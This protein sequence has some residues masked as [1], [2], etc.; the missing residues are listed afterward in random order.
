MLNASPKGVRGVI[1]DCTAS[2]IKYA[3]F[4][5]N[6][7]PTSIR[8]VAADSAVCDIHRAATSAVDATAALWSRIVANNAIS[9]A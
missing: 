5:P 2:D 9:K 4:M 7:S 1:A 8:G 3:S 6:A